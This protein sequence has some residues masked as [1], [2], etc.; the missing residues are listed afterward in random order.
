MTIV[1]GYSDM[2]L[3]DSFGTLSVD[4]RRYMQKI[5]DSTESLIDLVNNILD[6]SKIEAGRFEIVFTD[7]DIG[8]VV[9]KCRENFSTLYKEKNIELTLSDTSEKRILSTDAS[10]LALICNNLLSNAYKFTKPGGKVSIEVFD[11]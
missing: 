2:F 5:Y 10:K 8:V 9:A 4:A 3:K 1:K 7:V 6:I 11:E